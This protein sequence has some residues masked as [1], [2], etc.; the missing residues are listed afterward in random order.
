MVHWRSS[1]GM[2]RAGSSS[3]GACRFWNTTSW[4]HLAVSPTQ[5]TPVQ[6][7]SPIYADE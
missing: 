5:V 6:W 1:L 7:T 4:H 2:T 3:L